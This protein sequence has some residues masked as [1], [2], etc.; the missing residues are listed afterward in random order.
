MKQVAKHS[1]CAD[2]LGITNRL[3]FFFFVCFN[4]GGGGQELIDLFLDHVG[5]LKN[6]SNSWL[7]IQFASP[8]FYQTLSK[9]WHLLLGI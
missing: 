3:D 9:G 2:I 7:P 8:F 5:Q 6:C 4:G 1:V